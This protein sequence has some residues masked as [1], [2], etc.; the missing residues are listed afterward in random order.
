MRAVDKLDDR[1]TNLRQVGSQLLK[2]LGSNAF[3]FA[4]ESEQD[5]FGSD[6]V[7]AELESLAQRQLQHLLGAG[8]ERD[9]T[10]RGLLALTDDLDNLLAN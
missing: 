3:A 1:L 6:V 2:D 5:V 9:M 4:N 10:A 7:V 8:R